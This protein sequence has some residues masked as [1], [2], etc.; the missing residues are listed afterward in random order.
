ME[1]TPLA[2][3]FPDQIDGVVPAMIFAVEGGQGSSALLI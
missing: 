3:T 1:V 2:I